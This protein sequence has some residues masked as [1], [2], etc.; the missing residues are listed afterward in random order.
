M[1]VPLF[2][3]TITIRN[4]VLYA[5]V[6][7]RLQFWA[8]MAVKDEQRLLERLI[9]SGGENRTAER[10]KQSAEDAG[11]W[12]KLV[13]QYSDISELD[14]PLLNTLIE[15][16]VIHEGKKARTGFGSRKWKFITV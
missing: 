4:D 15:K 1:V 9:Q 16:I 11:K 5:Y 7:D 12:I 2:E 8:A 3:Y 14:A 13:R 10:K 6:L